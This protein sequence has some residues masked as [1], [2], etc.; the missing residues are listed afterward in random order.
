MGSGH[1]WGL[2]DPWREGEQ[3][4]GGHAGAEGPIVP[5]RGRQV[6]I[7]VLRRMGCLPGAEASGWAGALVAQI[8]EPLGIC[9]LSLAGEK[10]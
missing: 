3:Q 7:L 1:C 6:A 9:G 5:W 10:D 2:F 4:G 8:S